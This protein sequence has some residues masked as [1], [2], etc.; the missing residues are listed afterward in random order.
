VNPEPDCT[1][2]G[3]CC[4]NPLENEAEGFRTWVEVAPGEPLLKRKDLVRKLVVVDADGGR[5]LR[6]DRDGRCLALQGALGRRVSCRI[7]AQRPKPCR[8]VQAGDPD[9]LRYRAE[10]GI[11]G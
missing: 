6:L 4:V 2:C 5:H 1:T 8:R 11:G 7:Y 10:R 9:C 3:A